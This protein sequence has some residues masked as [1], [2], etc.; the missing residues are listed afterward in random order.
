MLYDSR[1]AESY[2]LVLVICPNCYTAS[3]SS[4][5]AEIPAV[6]GKGCSTGDCV[7]VTTACLKKVFEA[8]HEVIPVVIEHEN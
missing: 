7:N 6:K 5:I 8:F 3:W 1:M 4:H 2:L